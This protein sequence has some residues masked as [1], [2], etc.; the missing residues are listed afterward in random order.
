MLDVWVSSIRNVIGASGCRGLRTRN[1]T[2]S[3]T[4]ESSSSSPSSIACI[5]ATDIT[6]FEIDVRLASGRGSR[7]R[8]PPIDGASRRHRLSERSSTPAR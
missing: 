1:G 3:F 4:S 6:V 7:R 8:A 5:T 2:T